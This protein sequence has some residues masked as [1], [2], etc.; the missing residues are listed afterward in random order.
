M[1]SIFAAGWETFGPQSA[2][3]GDPR[4]DSAT[5]RFRL[6][7]R[8]ARQKKQP[9]IFACQNLIAMPNG[10]LVSGNVLVIC[11]GLARLCTT[12]HQW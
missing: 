5:A 9:H 8:T 4:T 6:G 12:S 11:H 7:R 3:S 10:V 2:G 1:F